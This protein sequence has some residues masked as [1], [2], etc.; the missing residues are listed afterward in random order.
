V[1][2]FAWPNGADQ[3]DCAAG[4]LIVL[5]ISLQSRPKFPD[6]ALQIPCSMLC[7]EG[8]QPLEIRA[9]RL[10]QADEASGKRKIFLRSF[11]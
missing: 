3:N 5:F 7:L 2:A 4:R 6:T 10:V 11:L 1:K 8:E 9:T